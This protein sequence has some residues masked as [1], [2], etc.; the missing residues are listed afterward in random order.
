MIV[1]DKKVF[2]ASFAAE[3]FMIHKKML[4]Y[5]QGG[6]EGTTIASLAT[7]HMMFSD[8]MR[9]T[10]VESANHYKMFLVYALCI[11]GI[12][13]ALMNAMLSATVKICECRCCVLL[14]WIYV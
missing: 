2:E 6:M 9:N 10:E 7:I 14:E 11:V 1:A 8:I 5:Y 13:C 3:N 4:T 12:V